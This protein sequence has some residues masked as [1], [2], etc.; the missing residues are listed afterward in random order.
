MAVGT[1]STRRRR[2][3]R[4]SFLAG[5]ERRA[6]APIRVAE[7]EQSVRGRPALRFD[8]LGEAGQRRGLAQQRRR[9]DEAAKALLAAHEALVNQ[10][11]DGA[12]DREAADGEAL[13][14]DRLAIHAL[15]R[16]LAADLLPKPVGKL[17][18]KR[19][20]EIGLQGGRHMSGHT[21]DWTS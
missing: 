17:E 13:G 2:S 18:V 16:S 3:S 8:R 15:P 10:D 5:G 20:V 21:V 4:T 6:F 11:F 19:P 14:Q 1:S 9:R 7:G 12:R